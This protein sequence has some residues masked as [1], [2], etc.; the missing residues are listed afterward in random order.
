MYGEFMIDAE[1]SRP[2]GPTY[3]LYDM[4][5]RIEVLTQDVRMN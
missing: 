1:G 5:R 4:L 3:V 2:Q